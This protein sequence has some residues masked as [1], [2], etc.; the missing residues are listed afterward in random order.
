MSEMIAQHLAVH[1]LVFLLFLLLPV[2]DSCR[3]MFREQSDLC[4]AVVDGDDDDDDD[5][6]TQPQGCDEMGCGT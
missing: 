4:V 1:E 3:Q 5:L 6:K 2:N